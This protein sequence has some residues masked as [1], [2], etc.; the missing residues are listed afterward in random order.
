MHPL[1][2]EKWIDILRT[3]INF[4]KFF[5]QILNQGDVETE[6]TNKTKLKKKY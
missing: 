2:K 6:N 3:F 1:L 5:L 4:R